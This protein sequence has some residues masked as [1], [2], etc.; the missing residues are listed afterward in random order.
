ARTPSDLRVEAM[1]VA[2]R[3][4]DGLRIGFGVQDAGWGAGSPPVTFTVRAAPEGAA[5]IPLWSRR[6][7][8]ARRAGDR[9]WIDAEVDLA[10]VADRTASFVFTAEVEGGGAGFPAWAAPA[11]VRTRAQPLPPS[12]LLVSLDTVRADHLTLGGYAR[13]TSPALSAF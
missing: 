13:A 10:A 9:G 1:P 4:G 7:D 11:L 5:A 3:S 12:L 8:P 6:L 2:V